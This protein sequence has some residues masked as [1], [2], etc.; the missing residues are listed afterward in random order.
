MYN[1]FKSQS[2]TII[3]P[4]YCSCCG[5]GISFILIGNILYKDFSMMVSMEEGMLYFVYG[6]RIY[7]YNCWHKVLGDC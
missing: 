2:S 4:K 3:S 6:N 1:E 7:H 5:K